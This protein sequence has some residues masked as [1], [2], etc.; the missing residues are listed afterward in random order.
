M[1]VTKLEEPFNGSQAKLT[2]DA[3]MREA[4]LSA[5]LLPPRQK[6]IAPEQE[7][8]SSLFVGVKPT[9]VVAA[10]A[11]MGITEHERSL[12]HF[13]RLDEP[14]S[15]RHAS[16]RRMAWVLLDY[17]ELYSKTPLSD[18]DL[19]KIGAAIKA[20]SSLQRAKASREAAA[21]RVATSAK[22]P[23]A[24]AATSK[25]PSS[26]A[27]AAEAPSL[28]TAQA[29]GKAPRVRSA[30]VAAP[31]S[32]RVSAAL[33][34][35][36]AAAAAAESDDDEA[37]VHNTREERMPDVLSASDDGSAAGSDVEEEGS[38]QWMQ[39]TAEDAACELLAAKEAL[40]AIMKT[41][42][43]KNL[44]KQLKAAQGFVSNALQQCDRVSGV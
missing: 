23:T 9:P 40:A 32:G 1:S 41:T 6:L 2:K 10:L 28:L 26:A 8:L 7:A 5:A 25:E 20:E 42:T 37:E 22:K 3:K 14:K 15:Y 33:A 34:A 39:N 17:W 31:K 13:A 16:A 44:R 35:A 29:K 12:S 21:S 38:V 11:A 30:A 36:A 19:K 24:V 27:A 43:D 4:L 18:K